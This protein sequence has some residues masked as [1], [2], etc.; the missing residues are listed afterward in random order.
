M[1]ASR[2]GSNINPISISIDDIIIATNPNISVIP[3]TFFTQSF[4]VIISK[5]IVVEL[6]GTISSIDQSIGI[7]NI[8]I[9]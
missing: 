7:D 3:W 6:S 5:M 2:Y 9:N 1:F 8:N 4:V